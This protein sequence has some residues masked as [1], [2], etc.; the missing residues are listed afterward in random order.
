MSKDN[1][2]I[3]CWRANELK[4]DAIPAEIHLLHI[5]MKDVF[6][7]GDEVFEDMGYKNTL[8]ETGWIGKYANM[9]PEGGLSGRD[10][11]RRKYSDMV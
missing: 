1:L 8:R 2:E 10:Y 7:I 6:S 4:S 9:Q 3:I 11:R 5:H